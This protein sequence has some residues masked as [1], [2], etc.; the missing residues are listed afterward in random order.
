MI[1]RR[2]I[3]CLGFS[4]LISWGV[5][6]YLIGVFGEHIVSD[7]GWSREFVHGGFSAA[8]R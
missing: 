7:L 5:S 1:L 6:Y 3:V 4:Q 8:L 2:A